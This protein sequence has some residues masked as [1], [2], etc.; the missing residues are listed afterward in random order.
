MAEEV[1][2]ELEHAFKQLKEEATRLVKDAK[3]EEIRETNGRLNDD[4]MARYFLMRRNQ[5]RNYDRLMSELRSLQ[6][7]EAKAYFE[8]E[9]MFFMI[10]AIGALLGKL[11]FI[12]YG[13]IPPS[14]TATPQRRA[15]PQP[16]HLS[17]LPQNSTSRLEA[18]TPACQ[19]HE[20]E[21]ESPIPLEAC[22]DAQTIGHCRQNET[23]SNQTTHPAMSA[24][25]MFQDV[26]VLNYLRKPDIELD[27]FSGDPIK[28]Q[29]FIR[30]FQKKIVL[31]VRT[32]TSV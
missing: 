17:P 22:G 21:S 12:V 13:D 6:E 20:R 11:N 16:N 14:G 28:Y 27:K 19:L 18:R 32:R 4:F 9:A 25:S 24:S 15:S 10:P 2:N 8:D 30:R 7:P 23:K 1:I 5:L 3:L 29:K 31:H 26:N